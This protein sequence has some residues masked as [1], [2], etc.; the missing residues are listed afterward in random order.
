MMPAHDV[1]VSAI[2]SPSSPVFI[3]FDTDGGSAIAPMS[4]NPGDPLT[5]PADPT[6]AGYTFIGWSPSIPPSVPDDDATYTAMWQANC[7]MITFNANGGT[8]GT[9]ITLECGSPLTPPTVARTGFVFAGGRQQLPATVGAGDADYTALWRMLGDLT[10]NDSVTS[11]DALLA[12]QASAEIIS[13]TEIQLLAA[14]VNQSGTVT[15]ADALK[16]LQYSA[17]LITSF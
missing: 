9:S 14:D 13:P 2:W 1:T 12:L 7:Y 10:G 4:G 16:I 3:A 17:G 6:R 8:G 15:S 5:P 11:A